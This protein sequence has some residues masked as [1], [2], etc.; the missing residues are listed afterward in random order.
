MIC[1]A[2]HAVVQDPNGAPNQSSL[3]PFKKKCIILAVLETDGRTNATAALGRVVIDLSEFAAIDQ[4]ETRSFQVACAKSV[5]AAVGDPYLTITIRCAGAGRCS[6]L[7][8]NCM[9][10]RD[11]LFAEA[12]EVHGLAPLWSVSRTVQVPMEGLLQDRWC[13]WRPG[14]RRDGIHEHGHNG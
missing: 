11:L 14:C 12:V 4:Q 13:C 3:G 8:G 7:R 1:L 10:E 5:H 6:L 2:W 9:A